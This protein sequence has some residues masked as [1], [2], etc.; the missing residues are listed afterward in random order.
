ME[1]L[2]RVVGVAF[3]ENGKLLI[4]KSVRSS[5]TNSW[6]LVGGGIE[7]GE[8]EITAA[9]RE[10][11]EEIGQGFEFCEEDLLPIMCFKEAAESD[12]DVIIEMNMF[13][14][15]KKIHVSLIPN[16]E[17][18]DYHWYSLGET[19]FNLSSSIRDRF[20]PYAIQKGLIF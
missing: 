5:A 12:S 3:I 7:A 6:T 9:L 15:T 19:E 8:T 16:D 20:L 17:I 2:K 1:R 11:N 4:V 18:L 13:L 14:A 10:V